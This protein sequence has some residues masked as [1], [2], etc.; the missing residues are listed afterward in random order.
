[1]PFR[2]RHLVRVHVHMQAYCRHFITTD[3]YGY[4]NLVHWY[5]GKQSEEVDL[6]LVKIK[7]TV[8]ITRTITSVSE[9]KLW[10]ASEW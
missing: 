6:R 5:I 8:E 10:K 9:R 2:A 7:P 3:T 1:M 4:H